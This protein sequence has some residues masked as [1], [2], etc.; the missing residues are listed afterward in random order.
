MFSRELMQLLTIY[1]VSSA[2]NNYQQRGDKVAISQSFTEMRQRNNDDIV[3][4]IRLSTGISRSQ[5]AKEAGLAKATVSAIVDELL[6]KQMLQEIGSQV[7]SGGRPAVGL[8]LNPNYGYILGISIDFGELTACILD[9]EGTIK[10]E[11]QIQIHKNWQAQQLLDAFSKELDLAITSS[12]LTSAQLL[13]TGIAAPGPIANDPENAVDEEL[14]EIRRFIQLYKSRTHSAVI[15]ETNAN[16]SAVA[17]I[18]DLIV[19]DPGIILVVRIGH[20]VRSA[21]LQGGK[22]LTG[23]GGYGGEF[24]HIKVSNNDRICSCGAVGCLNTIAS[25]EAILTR[26]R[27][28]GVKV[29]NI[30]ELVRAIKHGNHNLL[31]IFNDA[32][33]AIGE[34]LANCIN[35]FAPQMVVISGRGPEA[36]DLLSVPIVKKI[37]HLAL[38]ENRARCR[39]LFG[40]AESN[41]ECY[42]AALSA[43]QRL[44]DCPI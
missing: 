28:M 31:V 34:A 38:L 10:H 27:Q 35:L 7:S 2:V 3:R 30:K 22:L 42:G 11:W 41:S 16:M 25:T 4:L 29:K 13:G 32:G 1:R 14:K 39:I 5:L 21:L 17:E 19:S 20:Q 40:S 18:K 8:A 23:S 36:S 24:G 15:V 33:D 44:R 12:G 43:T 37:D 6:K 9:L 26:A